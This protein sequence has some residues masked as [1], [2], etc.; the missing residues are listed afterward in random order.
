[1]QSGHEKTITSILPE[2]AGASN[3]YGS[4]MVE[5]GMSFSLEQ[6]VLDNEFI[7]MQKIA[8]RGIEVSSKT[9]AIGSIDEIGAGRDFLA[10]KDT[11]EHMDM[12]SYSNV[13][14]RDMLD[15]WRSHGSKDIIEVAN[16]KV[17]HI[18]ANVPQRTPLS[19]SQ[20]ADIDKI[21]K[22]ADKLY[23]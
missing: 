11:L 18:L 16:E 12:L 19:S 1:M 7:G 13:I 3:I 4:G 5:L 17:K 22:N 23:K 20:R 21:I 10:H 15:T 6:L 14:D 8:A 9:L 2:L